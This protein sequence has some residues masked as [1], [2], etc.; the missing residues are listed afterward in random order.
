MN[1]MS[2]GRLVFDHKMWNLFDVEER[3]SSTEIEARKHWSPS[4]LIT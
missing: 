4:T 3:D 2:G 1:Q